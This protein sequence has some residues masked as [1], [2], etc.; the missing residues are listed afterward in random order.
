MTKARTVAGLVVG[1]FG[2]AAALHRLRPW[3]ASAWPLSALSVPSCRQSRL[4]VFRVAYARQGRR[5]SHPAPD[6]LAGQQAGQDPGAA[7]ALLVIV[8]AQYIGWTATIKAIVG[9]VGGTKP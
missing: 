2:N 6:S 5:V 7:L 8:I 1:M 9:L 4:M 3:C